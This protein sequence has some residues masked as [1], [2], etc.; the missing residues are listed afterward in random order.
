M[1][2]HPDASSP[3]EDFTHK[4]FLTVLQDREVSD[5]TRIL[6]CTG[7]IGHELHTERK[8][9]K[10][11]SIAIVS[12]EQ[13]YPFPEK[14]LESAVGQYSSAR[15]IVWVQEEPVNMGALSYMLPR[16]RRIAGQRS[17]LSIK[18]SASAS[19]TL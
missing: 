2:R 16:L 18:R 17:V 13:L 8:N 3:I 5:A 4:R 11:L 10:D 7:K 9:R 15:E 12:V 1:L 6:I 14:E 19:P